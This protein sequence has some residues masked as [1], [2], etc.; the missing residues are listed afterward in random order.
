[1]ACPIRYYF[2]SCLR[3]QSRRLG[4]FRLNKFRW[5]LHPKS[6]TRAQH[7]VGNAIGENVGP[8]IHRLVCDAHPTSGGSDGAA[9]KVYG[10]CFTHAIL[11]HA[12]FL[13]SNHALS[14]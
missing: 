14:S 8:L 1:M 10:L 11:K 12:F 6:K 4:L 7:A 13:R 3:F 5:N 2:S 9:E